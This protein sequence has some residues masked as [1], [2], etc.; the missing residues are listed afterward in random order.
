[1][2][3]CPLRPLYKGLIID[4][5]PDDY[6]QEKSSIIA[7]GITSTYRYGVVLA[8][9]VDVDYYYEGDVVMYTKDAAYPL[10]YEYDDT[11]IKKTFHIIFDEKEL[12][13]RV[14]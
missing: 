6:R 3:N 2:N 7:T 12:F 5:Y 9:G 8:V 10:E 13:G 11:K 1:M 14:S 4:Q